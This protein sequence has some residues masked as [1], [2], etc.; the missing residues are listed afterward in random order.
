MIGL[1]RWRA[2]FNWALL[3]AAVLVVC[4]LKFQVQIGVRLVLPLVALW[5]VGLASAMVIAWRDSPA[6]WKRTALTA[7]SVLAV[8]WTA[9]A[10]LAVWPNALCYTNELWGSRA[11]AYLR[12][13]D[14]NYDWGQGLPELAR[15]QRQHGLEHLDLWYFGSDP[16]SKHAP[17]H[18]LS[19]EYMKLHNPEDVAAA[20]QGRCLAVSTT[21][22]YG[23]AI[24]YPECR[25]AIAFLRGCQPIGRTSTFFVYDFTALAQGK[26]KVAATAGLVTAP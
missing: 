18:P 22:L 5:T 19:L 8:S 11:S 26:L 2:L 25:A 13:S 16:A 10:A 4:S 1:L 23:S 6:G 24:E 9:Q 14:G 20:L 21:L 15:W 7:C 12:V 3:G 17:F